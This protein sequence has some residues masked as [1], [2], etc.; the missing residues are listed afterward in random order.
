[1]HSEILATKQFK[2]INKAPTLLQTNNM[3]VLKLIRFG[4]K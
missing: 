4:E 2:L 1:M 3:Q